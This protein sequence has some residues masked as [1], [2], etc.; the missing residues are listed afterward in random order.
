MPSSGAVL[1]GEK[2]SK[3]RTFFREENSHY[4]F[5]FSISAVLPG[6]GINFI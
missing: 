1:T 4:L 2:S 5:E 3:N 6:G